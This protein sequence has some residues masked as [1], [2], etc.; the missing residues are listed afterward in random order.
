MNGSNLVLQFS[1]FD[2]LT[3]GK[4]KCNKKEDDTANA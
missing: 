2:V 4:S 1:P 3:N